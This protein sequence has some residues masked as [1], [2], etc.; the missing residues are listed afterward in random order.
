MGRLQRE[1]TERPTF[2]VEQHD[3]R[4][5]NEVQQ[6]AGSG[7]EDVVRC[8]GKSSEADGQ[9]SSRPDL[10]S[11]QRITAQPGQ[12]RKARRHPR[13]RKVCQVPSLKVRTQNGWPHVRTGQ[14]SLWAWL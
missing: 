6:G 2:A 14:D 12:S 11:E 10:P 8:D 9:A 7:R 1:G 4:T 3:Q 5:E 13:N